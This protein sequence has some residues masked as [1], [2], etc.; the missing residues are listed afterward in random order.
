[1][2]KRALIL[3]ALCSINPAQAGLFS[4]DDA[5]KQIQQVQEQ[6][7]KSQEQQEKFQE[8]FD[9]AQERVEKLSVTEQEHQKQLTQS[10]LDLQ[11]QIEALTAEIRSLRGQ[12]EELAHGLQNAEKREKDFYIDLDTRLRRFESAGVPV[13]AGTPNDAPI[14]NSADGFDPTQENRVLETGYGLLRGKSYLNAVKA[15]KEFI[16]RYPDSVQIPNAIYG[17]GNAQYGAADYKGALM[18]YQNFLNDYPN[19]PR[20]PEVMLNIAGCQQGLHHAALAT[21]TL[22]LL[23]SKYPNSDAAAKAKQQ[24][25]ERR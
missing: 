12:N 5:R 2:L 22:K 6:L 1:M 9:K 16:T 14:A 13:S 20:T 25:A 4:D 3:L 23:I 11:S 18:V 15:F 21:K 19:T 10:V 24:L 8:Q 17:L 7:E